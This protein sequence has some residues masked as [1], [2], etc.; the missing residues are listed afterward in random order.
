MPEDFFQIRSGMIVTW[1]GA[2]RTFAAETFFLKTGESV[3]V[4][5]RAFR[6]Y[7]MLRGMMQFRIENQCCY[8]LKLL[9]VMIVTDRI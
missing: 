8:V 3:I 2:L 7:F 1:T 9:S 5:L 4:T 6:A